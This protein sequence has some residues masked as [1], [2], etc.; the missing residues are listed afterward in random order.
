MGSYFFRKVYKLSYEK[1]LEMKGDTMSKKKKTEYKNLC[2]HLR[3]GFNLE[4]DEDSNWY[5]W[6]VTN[7]GIVVMDKQGRWIAFVNIN[8]V[9]SVEMD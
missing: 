8:D 3:Q 6:E 5:D 2:I 9:V 7:L 4:Y 1:R